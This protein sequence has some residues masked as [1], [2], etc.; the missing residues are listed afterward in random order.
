MLR[1]TFCHIPGIGPKLEHRLWTMG[2]ESWDSVLDKGGA[3][4]TSKRFRRV[5][6]DIRQ[7]ITE[8]DNRNTGFF[9]AR[10]PAEEHW[11]F[12]R[13]FRH[14]V[15][16][17]DIETDG[18]MDVDAI[19][20]I[21]L[22]DGREVRCYVRDRNLDDFAGDIQDYKLLVTYSGKCFDVPVIERAFNLTLDAAHIDLRYVL[23][24]LGF[25]GGL[26]SCEKQLGIDRGSLDGVDG[27]F[28]VLLWRDFVYTGNERALETLLA[29]NAEDV[30]NLEPLMIHAYNM[31]VRSTPFART[32]QVDCPLRPL[33]PYR[34]D[35]E[36][37]HRL[38]SALW[39]PGVTAA[40]GPA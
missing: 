37:V 3:H 20:T 40:R 25:R 8:L 1:N 28:A 34:A 22:Y 27:Y 2:Y 23:H 14:S 18:S 32:H 16:Y 11:R 17:L 29:Y 13:E 35:V 33:S 30:L 4:L 24:S 10:M 7:S 21:A 36:T 39:R 38:R 26:K 19:T 5:P 6:E 12:F 15:A 9:S 31:K